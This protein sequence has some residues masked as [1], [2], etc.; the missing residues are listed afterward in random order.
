MR[1]D[2]LKDRL[3]FK[4]DSNFDKFFVCKMLYFVF[5]IVFVNGFFCFSIFGTLYLFSI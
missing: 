1:L 2:N 4:M 5:F 3:V